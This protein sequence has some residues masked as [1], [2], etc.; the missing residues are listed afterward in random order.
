MV[1]WHRLK[2]FTSD[3]APFILLLTTCFYLHDY[4]IFSPKLSV[5]ILTNL[6][7][8]KKKKQVKQFE[9]KILVLIAF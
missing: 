9:I 1:S 7:K 5:Y 3:G 8:K 4:F 6:S 2:H